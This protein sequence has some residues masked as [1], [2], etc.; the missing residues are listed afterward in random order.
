MLKFRIAR[1]IDVTHD[2]EGS[3][4]AYITA[5]RIYSNKNERSM[6]VVHRKRTGRRRFECRLSGTTA[7]NG[8][9][10]PRRPLGDKMERFAWLKDRSMTFEK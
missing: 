6:W 10:Q 8:G 9:G 5:K 3:T 7:G 2:A 1:E 4:I